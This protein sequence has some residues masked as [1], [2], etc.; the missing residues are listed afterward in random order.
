MATQEQATFSATEMESGMIKT[1]HDDDG[2]MKGGGAT[3]AVNL[4]PETRT[5]W[6]QELADLIA[7]A[8]QVVSSFKGGT[9]VWE[10]ARKLGVNAPKNT[11]THIV[12]ERQFTYGVIMIQDKNLAALVAKAMQA[13]DNPT[14]SHPASTHTN[15]YHSNPSH[16]TPSCPI[17]SHPTAPRPSSSRPNPSYTTQHAPPTLPIT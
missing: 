13:A 17:P 8:P 15:P 12:G 16:S 2:N 11:R 6:C 9:E 5:M 1:M 7:A 14:P 10:R 4:T 3:I